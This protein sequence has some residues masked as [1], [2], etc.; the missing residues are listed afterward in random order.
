[1]PPLTWTR[2]LMLPLDMNTTSDAPFIRTRLRIAPLDL[3]IVT[4]HP[5]WHELDGPSNYP[6]HQHTTEKQLDRGG[7][8][9][10]FEFYIFSWRLKNLRR[11]KEC[12]NMT[13]RWSVY[14]DTH[15]NTIG[16]VLFDRSC[17]RLSPGS[18]QKPWERH[19]TSLLLTTLIRMI[20]QLGGV[21]SSQFIVC[22]F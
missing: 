22:C 11:R 3:N 17:W 9:F 1:M 2:L 8:R 20:C 12:P 5:P 13:L 15:W 4:D 21:Y 14:L 6:S 18:Q 10:A 16:G 7:G 19:V